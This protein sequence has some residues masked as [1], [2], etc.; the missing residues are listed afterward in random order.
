MTAW[1]CSPTVDVYAPEKE[2]YVVYGVLNPA[3]P[4][5]YVTVTKVFQYEGDVYAYAGEH[6]MTARGLAVTLRAD[7]LVW[8]ATLVEVPDTLPNL[9]AKTTGAYRFETVGAQ[10]LQPGRRYNLEIRKPDDPDFGIF[11]H[12]Q[13]PTAPILTSPGPPIYSA[14]EGLYTFPSVEFSEEQAIYFERGTGNGFEVRV[15]VEYMDHD[16]RHVARWGPTG[17]FQSAVRCNANVGVGEGCYEIPSAAVP[18]VLHTI[19][20]A[21]DDT[22][23]VHD[24]I[25]IAQTLDSLSR[26][27]WVEVTAVDSA[28]TA[29]LLA[30]SPFGYGL[31]LL[32]DKREYSNISGGNTGVF[33]AIH[34]H[35]NYVFLGSCTR[36]LAGLRGRRPSGCGI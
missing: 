28:M 21:Y 7:S 36:W 2:L 30:N 27:A 35:A 31:N 13:I 18:N 25:R 5:Q 10:A 17:I 3:Q 19:F 14:Q 20:A 6:D 26:T 24:T 22:V 34:T 29:Y 33:G 16:E 15:F 1:G 8:Q 32:M 12:T 23:Y 4:V 11:A 9:F